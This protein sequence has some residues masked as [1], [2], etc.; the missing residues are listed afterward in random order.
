MTTLCSVFA[1]IVTVGEAG[2]LVYGIVREP[3]SAFM[4][5]FG[6]LAGLGV[7]QS[8]F[9]QGNPRHILPDPIELE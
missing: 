9:R 7:G 3:S 6:A 5:I 8:G 4:S 2:H 1:L